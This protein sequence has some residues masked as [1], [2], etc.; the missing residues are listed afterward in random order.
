[1]SLAKVLSALPLEGHEWILDV[2]CGTGELER[3]LFARWPDLHITGVDLCP[4]MLAQAR[5]KHIAGDV[6]WIEG[7]ASHLPVPDGGF[8]RVV[9]ANS[10]HYFRKPMESLQEIR[11][12]LAPA[13]KLILVDWCDDYWT[14]KLCSLWLRLTDPAF[15]CT[16]TLQAGRNMLRAAGFDTTHAER[17]KVSWLWG[18]MLFV[19]GKTP[20]PRSQPQNTP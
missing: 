1:V 7:E 14:C 19:C 8:D 6:T 5:D 15:F 18:M 4:R 13:G 2:A 11:R 10:F 12:C 9:C 16:Y 17:F 20:D 3:R